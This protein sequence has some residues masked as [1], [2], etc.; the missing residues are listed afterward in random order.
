M[1]VHSSGTV[2]IDVQLLRA[3]LA[4]DREAVVLTT[5]WVRLNELKFWVSP[6]DLGRDPPRLQIDHS[7]AQVH[8]VV[9]PSRRAVRMLSTEG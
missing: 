4:D 9:L 1:N 8:H 5:S 3:L 6:E 2:E 7:F